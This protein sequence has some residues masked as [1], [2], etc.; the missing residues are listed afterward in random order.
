MNNTATIDGYEVQV[1]DEL[2]ERVQCWITSERHR[3][4]ASLAALEQTGELGGWDCEG[5]HAVAVDTVDK[6]ITWADKHGYNDTKES[7]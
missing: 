3:A 1:E 6:I 4:S 2:T 5:D 7:P